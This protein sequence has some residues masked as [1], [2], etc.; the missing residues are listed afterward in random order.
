MN[1]T[2][3]ILIIAILAFAGASVSVYKTFTQK[4]VWIDIAE[5]YNDFGLKKELE[6]KMIQTQTARKKILDSLE[7]ELQVLTKKLD[8]A[9]TIADEDKA[10]YKAKK[11]AFMSKYNMYKEEDDHM[12]QS[13][14]NQIIQQLNQYIK[15]YGEK[16]GYTMI[17]GAEGSGALMYASKGINITPEVKEYVNYRY[18]G[19]DK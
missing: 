7:F 11:E 14:E 10:V 19:G 5:V 4:T 3:L 9:K 12:K 2:N 15:D 8:M 6:S 1:K 17:L 16:K 18:S 13:F